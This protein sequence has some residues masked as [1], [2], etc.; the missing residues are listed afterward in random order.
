M[1]KQH[2]HKQSGDQL[3]LEIPTPP[4]QDRNHQKGGRSFY[5]FDFDDNVVNMLTTIVLFHQKSGKELPIT[6]QQMAKLGR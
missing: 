1:N 2:R 4:E 5:F 6:T 3:E